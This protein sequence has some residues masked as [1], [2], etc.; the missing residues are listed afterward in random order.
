[1]QYKIDINALID[2]VVSENVEINVTIQPD[3]TEVNI[4]PWKPFEMKCPYDNGKKNK[5]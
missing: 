4:Q 2:R 5:E 3:R 1:M